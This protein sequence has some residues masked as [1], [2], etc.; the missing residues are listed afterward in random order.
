LDDAVMQSPSSYFVEDGSYLRMK[1]L[2]I[3][4]TLPAS[5]LSRLKIER[6]RI[7][8]Q[9][10]NLFTITGYSGLD[11]EI[12]NTESNADRTMGVDEGCYPTSQIFMIGL[13]LNL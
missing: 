10:T 6:C 12:R 11:P 5:L 1:D 13:N 7:Y 4:Y 9:A 3:G 8:V 2:Q